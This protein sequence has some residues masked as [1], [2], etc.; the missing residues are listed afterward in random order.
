MDMR[1]LRRALFAFLIMLTML[2]MAAVPSQ[3][4]PADVSYMLRN[5]RSGK[6]LEIGFGGTADFNAAN[7]FTCHGADNQQW[8]HF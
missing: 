7:Q 5:Q 2:P 8:T 1:S 4:A 6:C 3:S